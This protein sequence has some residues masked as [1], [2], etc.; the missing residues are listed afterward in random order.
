MEIVHNER[1]RAFETVIDGARSH[2]D[3]DLAER[4]GKRQIIFTHTFVAPEH[5]G[6]GV[7]A[8]LVG[9]GL[10]FARETGREIVP[11]CSYVAQYLERHPQ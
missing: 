6:K 3:Y 11:A 1:E 8:A 4:D 9:A 5:R 10:D 2:L 7:A